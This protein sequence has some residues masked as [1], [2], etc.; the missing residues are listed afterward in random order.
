ML[1][2]D[3]LDERHDGGVVRSRLRDIRHVRYVGQTSGPRRRFLQHLN[4]ARL[5]LPDEKPWWIK[6]PKLLPL[7][8]WV[9]ELYR[10]ELRLPTMVIHTWVATSA[11]ARL[12]ERQRIYECL[13]QQLP[14]LNIETQALG[15]QIPLALCGSGQGK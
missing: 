12:A 14:L 6:S 10:E 8:Q 9:R 13:A 2:I 1:I 3:G 4:A 7:Y 5:W 15:K 11:E